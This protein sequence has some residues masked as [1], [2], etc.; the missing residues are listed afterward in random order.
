MP[1]IKDVAI[2][3]GLAVGT[4]SRVLNNRGYISKEARHRVNEAIKKLGYQPNE[5]ARLLQKKKS[6]QIGVIVPHVT[7]P[8]F[9]NLISYL[10]M[11]AYQHGY[12]IL[13]LNSQGL[14]SR[15][16][17]LLEECLRSHVMGI[18][19]CNG[20]LDLKTPADMN[21]PIITIERK[22]QPGD[23]AIECDNELGGVLA[24]RHL[25]S[26]GCRHLLYIGGV[27]DQNMPAQKR[28]YGFTMTCKSQRIECREYRVTL[29]N[30]RLNHASRI[31]ERFLEVNPKTD[32]VFLSDDILALEML[33]VC[34]KK[35]IKV[36]EDLKII[37]FDDTYLAALGNPT[38]T[39][40]R[41][42]VE[43][44][45]KQAVNLIINKE[46]GNPMPVRMIFPVELI[47]RET[48]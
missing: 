40:I 46:K 21:I 1:T 44:M 15:E 31:L 20:S 29:E 11:A 36:P 6:K 25:I 10:E 3:A 18:V 30:Y 5:A 9:A 37:G 16:S 14:E 7:H 17:E 22:M 42:P 35:G 38:L 13:L 2:E 19:L 26:C 28:G 45:A 33:Q 23:A 27:T 34:R 41:Q 8:Y 24:A 12:R 43:D 4:V 39:T 47:I 32:G 48:T